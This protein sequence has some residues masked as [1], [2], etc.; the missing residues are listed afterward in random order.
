[1]TQKELAEKLHI[2]DKAVSKWERDLSCPDIA[3]LSPLADILGVTVSE[4]LSGGSVQETPPDTEQISNAA[5]TYAEES[6]KGKMSSLHNIFAAVFS[7]LILLGIIVCL[8]CNAAISGAFTW[9]LYPISSCLFGWALFFP[10][11]KNGKKGIKYSLL[12]LSFL[13]LP[14]LYALYKLTGAAL[15]MK[16]GVPVS[17]IAL[18]FLWCVYFI[19]KKFAS[20]KFTAA[21]I[22]VLL[23]IPLCLAVNA[24]IAVFLS[25]AF[26][27]IWDLTA[28]LTAM[29]CAAVLFVKDRANAR[30]ERR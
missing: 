20:R 1:M 27:D 25:E 21:G 16:I 29:I 4:L 5:L 19:C 17:L 22:S 3:L 7:F 11:I 10:L 6:L 18:A 15:V 28:V 2:T 23:T 14:F 26:F 8:I 13:L 30:K 9:S 24:V 12:S